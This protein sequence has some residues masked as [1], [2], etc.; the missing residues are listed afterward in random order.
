MKM[1]NSVKWFVGIYLASVIAFIIYSLLAHLI[2]KL[3]MHSS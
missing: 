3:L 2:L 1:N